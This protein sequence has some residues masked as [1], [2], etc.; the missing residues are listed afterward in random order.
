M[1]QIGD[2]KYTDEQMI[3]INEYKTLI[4]KMQKYEEEM[5]KELL[6]KELTLQSS[7]DNGEFSKRDE[8]FLFE[9]I[10]N[11]YE[12]TNDEKTPNE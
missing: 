9:Y 8:E 12:I 11:H 6:Q 5:Y 2:Y 3:K 10:F 1:K 7:D 4:N